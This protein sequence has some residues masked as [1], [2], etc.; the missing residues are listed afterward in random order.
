MPSFSVLPTRRPT[1]FWWTD[2]PGLRQDL[3][4]PSVCLRLSGPEEDDY[5]TLV[6]ED[7][8]LF[9]IPSQHALLA[10]APAESNEV[11]P[12]QL[13]EDARQLFKERMEHARAVLPKVSEVPRRYWEECHGSP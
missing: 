3:L 4:Y 6:T 9:S 8:A 10:L 11:A 13:D 2:F 5:V 1:W 12:L 7:G